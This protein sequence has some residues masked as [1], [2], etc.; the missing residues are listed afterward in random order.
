VTVDSDFA[1]GDLC[2][3]RDVSSADWIVA[4]VR[5]FEYDVGSLVPLGFDAY[6]RVFHPA[7]LSDG[8]SSIEVS[9]ATVA[10]ANGRVAHAAMEWV[11]IT[12]DW[13]FL[14]GGG[15]QTGVWDAPPS[16]GSLPVRQAATL[17]A[18]LAA[19]TT[20]SSR[21]WFAIWDGYGDARY[22]RDA[23]K[24]A[25]P[26]RPMVLFTGPLSAATTSFSD[27]PGDQRAQLWWPDDHSWCV[28]TDVDLLTT[29]VGGS[30]E[31]IAAI[32][33]DPRLEALPV[34][35]DQSV[36]WQADTVNPTPPPEPPQTPNTSWSARRRM[37]RL[38]RAAQ[39]P[40]SRISSVSA[41]L[42][43]ADADDHLPSLRP[44]EDP[45]EDSTGDQSADGDH[46]SDQ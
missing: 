10:A 8:A 27:P 6:A 12:G 44:P 35:V 42:V 30:V 21:C 2:L 22:P 1:I 4:G 7:R 5:N 20:E 13:R 41:Q 36:T 37:A 28:A 40:G 29:Y 19:F 23:P 31:C 46:P 17:S 9:W 43:T 11:A 33:R 25:M 39:S 32:L 24:V 18:L 14:M 15:G 45:G 16:L 34:S 3:A 26:Q 38:R